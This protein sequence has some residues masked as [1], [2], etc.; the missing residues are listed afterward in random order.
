MLAYDVINLAIATAY[1]LILII[2]IIIPMKTDS[3]FSILTGAVMI[4]LGYMFKVPYFNETLL[5]LM[6]VGVAGYVSY[7]LFL[8]EE[9][10]K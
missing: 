2:A 5:V 4:L 7:A 9:F 6:I 1:S 10:S 8:K 3:R